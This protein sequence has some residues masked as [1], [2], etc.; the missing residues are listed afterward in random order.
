MSLFGARSYILKL[1]LTKCKSLMI[2]RIPLHILDLKIESVESLRLL[3]VY[4][5]NK[6]SWDSHVDHLRK[7]CSRRLHILRKL[8][9]LI[10][11]KSLYEVY[12]AIIRSKIDY[13]CP[14]FVGMNKKLSRVLQ[15]I[16]K[17]P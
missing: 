16:E 10:S 5:N 4:F 7:S 6:L 15:D 2:T 3:G 12:N 11:K 14:V 8:R 1:N 9:G 13:S 17:E